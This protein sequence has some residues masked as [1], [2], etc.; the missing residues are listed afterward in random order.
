M[1]N[2]VYS[3]ILAAGCSSR[4]KG[5]DKIFEKLCNGKEVIIN[6]IYKF[7][8]L[9]E[10]SKIIVV[11]RKN[12]INDFKKLIQKYK[13]KNEIFVV[14]G[15]LTRTQSLFNGFDFVNQKFFLTDDSYCLIHDGARPLIS[16]RDILNCLENAV[17][18]K[19]AALGVKINNT[20]KKSDANRFILKTVDRTDLFSIQT[21][22]IFQASLLNKAI[23]NAKNNNLDFTDDCQLI[24]SIGGKVYISE[25]SQLNIKITTPQDLLL[26]NNILK[27][28]EN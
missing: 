13:F 15:G 26:V 12:I 6:T 11:T 16:K 19:A 9:E 28:M 22:Q 27:V 14:E 4:I 1:K 7:D 5:T 10:S 21:P 8:E 17:K 25:G 24:E 23:I 3:I 20:V 2:V 18:Y